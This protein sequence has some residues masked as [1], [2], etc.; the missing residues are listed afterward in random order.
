MRNGPNGR[1][2][3]AADD[4]IAKGE[5]AKFRLRLDAEKP[6]GVAVRIG[7]EMDWTKQ[8][9]VY[10]FFEAPVDRVTVED[11][12]EFLVEMPFVKEMLLAIRGGSLHEEGRAEI[13][14]PSRNPAAT[15][16]PRRNRNPR[17]PQ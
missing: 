5:D 16:P 9:A 15:P 13:P 17:S 3:L 8:I 2:L 4:G 1:R 11:I 7:D 10:N 6:R 14:L 12:D